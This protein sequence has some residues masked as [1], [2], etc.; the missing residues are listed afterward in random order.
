MLR[1]LWAP[2]TK[3]LCPERHLILQSVSPASYFF[4][5]FLLFLPRVYLTEEPGLVTMREV[6]T[7]GHLVIFILLVEGAL[8]AQTWLVAAHE[9]AEVV[10]PFIEQCVHISA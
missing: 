9:A 7:K 3:L 8:L 6:K 2:G 5:N 10:Q 4:P 1:S